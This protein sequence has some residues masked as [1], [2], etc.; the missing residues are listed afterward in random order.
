MQPSGW[1]VMAMRIY[2]AVLCLSV[3]LCEHKQTSSSLKPLV[4]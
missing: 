4:F 1:Q 3:G 2:P